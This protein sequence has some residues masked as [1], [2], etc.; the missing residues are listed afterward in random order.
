MKTTVKDV[1]YTFLGIGYV[2]LFIMFLT[3]IQSIRDK[4]VDFGDSGGYKPYALF[5]SH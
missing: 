3:F 2:T 1:A 4:D 5:R